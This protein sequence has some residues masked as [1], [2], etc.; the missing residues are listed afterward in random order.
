MLTT[1][2][3]IRGGG[4]PMD[5]E[6]PM[7][8]FSSAK[9]TTK[10]GGL[11]NI[12]DGCSTPVVKVNHLLRQIT[13]TTKRRALGDVINTTSITNKRQSM[14]FNKSTTPAVVFKQQQTQSN[15]LQQNSNNTNNKVKRNLMTISTSIDSPLRNLTLSNNREEEMLMMEEED[16][17][18]VEKFYAPPAD[19][20]NDLFEETGGRLTDVFLTHNI[21]CTSRPGGIFA[22]N[23]SIDHNDDDSTLNFSIGEEPEQ[24]EE[25]SDKFEDRGLL[26]NNMGIEQWQ[27]PT[28]DDL[29]FK[30][31]ENF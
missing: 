28:E 1:A 27:Q 24:E 17:P 10:G 13:S 14:L 22:D 29:L 15:T 25:S 2:T 30:L 6:N 21:S 26:Q 31:P 19:T 5:K 12:N 20:F 18:P 7:D 3:A 4:I 11:G 9:K 23:T 8:I 16:L